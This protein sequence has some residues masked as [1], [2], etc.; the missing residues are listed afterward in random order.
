MIRTLAATLRRWQTAYT[1]LPLVA[2]LFLVICVAAGL[3]LY[4]LDA[5]GIWVDEK[6]SLGCAMGVRVGV[7]DLLSDAQQ[8]MRPPA[9]GFTSTWYASFFRLPNVIEGTIYDNGNAVGYNV[10]LFF[11]V[12]IFG[13]DDAAI[14]SLSVLLGLGAVLLGFAVA[15]RHWRES[16]AAMRVAWIL[17]LHPMLIEAS[18]TARGY[19]AAAFFVLAATYCWLR[20]QENTHRW[21]WTIAFSVA[22]VA[23]M[24]CHYF[25]GIILAVAC[26][27][28]IFTLKKNGKYLALAGMLMGCGMGYWLLHGGIAG[29]HEMTR[30]SLLFAADA[31][32][33]SWENL[34]LFSVRLWVRLSGLGIHSHALGLLTLGLTAVLLWQ[35]R[36]AYRAL[37]LPAGLL[38]G[39]FLFVAMLAMMAGHTMSFQSR[40]AAFVVPFAA[41]LLGYRRHWAQVGLLLLLLATLFLRTYHDT[42]GSG[43]VAAK[44]RARNPYMQLRDS[45]Q[46][47]YQSGDTVIYAHYIDATLANIYLRQH[48]HILQKIDTAL[49]SDAVLLVHRGTRRQ[50]LSLEGKRY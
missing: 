3:R 36:H 29:Y 49:H 4:R 43:T 42:E 6:M 16:E 28:W 9:D 23:A 26:L 22:G 40:Y 25:A 30:Q 2:Q 19:A 21:A 12:K 31:P 48:P 39:Y 50:L 17:A 27:A 14:R 44:D 24:L 7:E 37:L 45:V 8:P 32:T 18:Q 5:R 34:C 20:L 33:A 46:R 47:H 15:Q 1:A 38:V 10:L 11:W 35:Q 41:M 13:A